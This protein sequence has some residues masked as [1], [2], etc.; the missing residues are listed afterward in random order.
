MKHM[1]ND[2]RD[3]ARMPPPQIGKLDLNALVEE[4]LGLYGASHARLKVELAPGLPWVAGD[5]EQLRQVIHNLI[6]NAQDALA[7]EAARNDETSATKQPQP[8]ICIATRMEGR[9][10]LMTVSDNGGGFPKEM[11]ARAFEPYVTTK[12]KGTGLGLAIVK[13]I[14]DE[15]HGEIEIANASPHG[16]QVTIRLPLAA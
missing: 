11:L 5:A 1:V 8:E 12:T 6:A 9:G 13:K 2:F 4:V 16:A 15:H 14:V 10:A 3:Y 7:P